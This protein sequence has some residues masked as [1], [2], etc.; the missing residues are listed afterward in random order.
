MVQGAVGPVL[1]GGNFNTIVRLDER[2]SGNGRLSPDS[3]EFGEWINELSLIDMGFHG[4]QYTW[5]RGRVEN[6]FVA[7]RLDRVLCWAQ[8]RFRW[9]EASV[10]HL[11]FLA[12]DYAPLYVQFSPVSRGNAGRRPFWFEVAWLTHPGFKELLLTFWHSSVNTREALKKLQLVLKRW[13]KE[14]LGMFKLEKINC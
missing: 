3:L 12:S 13:N 10:T 8:T 9:Q 14:V 6:S 11:S 4:N 7:K 5:K 2:T 1:I